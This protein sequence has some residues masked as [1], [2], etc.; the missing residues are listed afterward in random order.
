V[1]F[2][3]SAMPDARSLREAI[4]AQV[5]DDAFFDDV[6]GTPAYKRHLTYLFAE[7]IRQELGTTGA[8]A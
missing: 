2:Y 1:Q 3:F 8:G 4:R 5:A 6:N 7:Q